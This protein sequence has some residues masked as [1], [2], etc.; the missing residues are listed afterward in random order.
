MTDLEFQIKHFFGVNPNDLQCLTSKFVEHSL[1]RNSSYLKSGHFC[2]KLSFIKSGYVRIFAEFKDKEVTQW[3]ATPGY[4]VTDLASFAFDIPA[5][6]SIETLSETQLY[7]IYKADYRSLGKELPMW[8]EIEKK[9]ISKCFVML[10]DRIFQHL[11]LSAEE[12]YIAFFESNRELFREVPLQYIAS[13][14]GM[15]PE[16]FS[17]V[18]KKMLE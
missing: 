3:I 14:L 16:T 9:F 15:T 18:R 8:H 6:F 4:F 10:E 1:P 11:S 5:R 17:R 13:M 12:R 7:T 2:D